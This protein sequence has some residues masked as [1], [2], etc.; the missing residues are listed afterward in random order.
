MAALTKPQ[1]AMGF[2]LDESFVID[3]NLGSG[4]F[5]TSIS[6]GSYYMDGSGSVTAPKDILFVIGAS[7]TSQDIANTGDATA[8]WTAT[9]NEDPT[10]LTATLI[11]KRT[12][13]AKTLSSLIFKQGTSGTTEFARRLIG[14]KLNTYTGAEA[15]FI[16]SSGTTIEWQ[17]QHQVRYLWQPRDWLLRFE[18]TPERVVALAKSVTGRVVASFYG[19]SWKTYTL[20]MEPVKGAL[21][22]QY[23]ADD[24]DFAG[25]I[26]G[27]TAGDPN[28]ALESFWEDY[29]SEVAA[30]ALP[31]IQLASDYTA[32]ATRTPLIFADEAWL[33]DMSNTLERVSMNPVLYTVTIDA[34]ETL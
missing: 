24:T 28:V 5:T 34:M 19:A 14:A 23:L 31:I 1:F 29:Q 25:D 20:Y 8:V 16:T 22:Y 13:V 15:E 17:S 21:V 6:A 12:G 2:T 30:G 11:L 3:I 4:V 26:A 9:L 7:I 33:K 18:T 32:P 10:T 27:M